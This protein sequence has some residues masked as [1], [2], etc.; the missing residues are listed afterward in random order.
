[1][2]SCLTNAY[3]I[4]K[5]FEG[6]VSR[7]D[8]HNLLEFPKTIMTD[9]GAYQLLI[10]GDVEIAPQEIVQYQEEIN[11]DIA[12]ILDVP[13]GWRVSREYALYTVEE[14][15]R[16]AQELQYT[17][18]RDDILWVGPV[19]GGQYLDLIAYS[20]KKMSLLNFDIHALGSPTP[21]MERYLFDMLV[22]MIVAAKSNLPPERPLHLFGA[23]HPFMFSLI[24]ALGCDLFDSAAYSIFARTDRYMTERGTL[25]LSKMSYLPC[26]CPICSKRSLREIKEM[27]KEE[28]ERNLCIHNL[29]VCFT[30]VKRIKQAI[31]EGRLWEHLEARAHSH[32]SLV[33]AV[34]R[35]EKYKS[36]LE[37]GSPITKRSGL[38]F[39]GNLSLIRPE[40]FR[41]RRRLVKRYRPPKDAFI[42]ILIQEFTS[43]P[44]KRVTNYNEIKKFVKKKFGE[45]IAKVV[46]ICLYSP[47]FGIIPVEIKG[48]Y[49]LS[50][51]EVALPFDLEM[52]NYASD[53]TAEYLRKYEYK[54][55]VLVRAEDNLGQKVS[56]ICRE[57]CKDKG[58]I[59]REVVSNNGLT[60]KTVKTVIEKI[61]SF[62]FN[63]FKD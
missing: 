57:I 42:L 53:V 52:I 21:V 62:L 39:Y 11:T 46:H 48:I 33:K 4:K 35:L 54:F 60:R 9:S 27:P 28:R 30:E 50:Q 47:P 59:F 61:S 37:E 23:G 34:K 56:K 14:T 31:A 17:K 3:I 43:C 25:R 38:F 6:D 20:A 63:A 12:T 45:K 41:H 7:L 40:V 58:I 13:T 5:R 32:P 44:A 16:R 8:V 15:I 24:I 22:D 55:V 49:P 26:S 1:M 18:S 29:Y 36:L 19:Q 2:R 10:Y 51:F